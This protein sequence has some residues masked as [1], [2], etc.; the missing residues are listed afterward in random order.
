MR[1]EGIM[2][3]FFVRFLLLLSLVFFVGTGRLRRASSRRV[4]FGLFNPERCEMLGSV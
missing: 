3:Q 4:K 1:L 2:L